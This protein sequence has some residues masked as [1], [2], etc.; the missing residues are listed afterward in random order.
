MESY[1]ILQEIPPLVLK[2]LNDRSYEKRKAAGSEIE[3]IV[4]QIYVGNV[5]MCSW[6]RQREIVNVSKRS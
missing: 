5:R 2:N 1:E 4:R 3:S 6:D